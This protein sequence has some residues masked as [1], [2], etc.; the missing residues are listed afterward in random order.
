MTIRNRLK[1]DY[2]N[3][4]I[5]AQPDNMVAINSALEIDLIAT[6]ADPG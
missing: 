2:T 4:L 1:N 6:T 3:V 5:I